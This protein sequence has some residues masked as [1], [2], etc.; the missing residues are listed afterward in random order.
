MKT[1]EP[2]EEVSSPGLEKR[3]ERFKWRAKRLL[4][5]RKTEGGLK[6]GLANPWK[7]KNITKK[8]RLVVGKKPNRNPD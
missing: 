5:R 1:M 4:R 3:L 7:S 6:D 8:P 2:S